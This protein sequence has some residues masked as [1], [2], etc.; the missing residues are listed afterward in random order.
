VYE[1][2]WRFGKL[3]KSKVVMLTAE[4]AAYYGSFDKFG[5]PTEAGAFAFG[6]GVTLSGMHFAYAPA[7]RTPDH[8]APGVPMLSVA[9]VALVVVGPH[10]GE[11]GRG[12]W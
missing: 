11:S 3:V 2:T 8:R 10:G 4:S 7:L 12:P 1:G 6:N 5:R 9:L